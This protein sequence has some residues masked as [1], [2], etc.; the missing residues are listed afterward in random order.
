MKRIVMSLLCLAL[1][2]ENAYSYIADQNLF[3]ISGKDSRITE[4]DAYNRSIYYIEAPQSL[5]GTI[6]IRIFDADLAGKHDRW[7]S[8]SEVRYY[9]YGKGSID[10]NVRTIADP[11]PSQNP[12]TELRLGE[13]RDYDDQWRTI[14]APDISEGDPQNHHVYFQ[15]IVDGTKGKA[16]NKYQVFVSAHDKENELVDG[17]RIFSPVVMLALPPASDLATQIR[18][19]VPKDTHYL[20]IFNFDADET[21]SKITIDFETPFTQPISITPSKDGQVSSTQ[22]TIGAEERGKTGAIIL[23]NG[24]HPN[25]IQLWI[26]DDQERPVP[27]SLPMF[28]APRNHVPVPDIQVIPLSACFSAMLDASGSVDPDDDELTFEWIFPDGSRSQGSRIVHDFSRSGDYDVTLIVRDQS[29]FVANSSKLTQTIR[30]NEPPMAKI[31]APDKGIPQESLT[32]DASDSWDADGQI[33]TYHWNFGDGT[34]GEGKTSSHK[35]AGSGK[36]KITLVIEDDSHSLCRQSKATRWVRINAPPVPHL[37]LK[38]IGAVGETI[39]LDA[40]ASV[41][42]DGEIILYAWD[43]G[44]TTTTRGEKTSHQWEAP[45]K[46]TVRLR[47]TDNAGLGNSTTEETAE[48]VINARP[49]ALAKYAPVIAAQEDVIFDGTVSYDQDGTIRKYVWDTGDGTIGEGATIHHAYESPGLYTATLTVTDNTS[50]LNNT[51]STT[52][53]IRVNHPPIPVAGEDQLVDASE[54]AFDASASMDADDPIIDYLWEFGDGSQA[55]GKVVSHVYALPGTYPVTLT[56]TDGSGSRSASQSDTIKVTVNHPPIADAGGTRVVSVGEKLVFDGNFSDDP[57]GEIVSYLWQ[58]EA[59]TIVKE[60]CLEH[61]YDKPGIYQVR[62][63]VQDNVGAESTDYATIIVNAP[64]VADFYPVRRVAPGQTVLFDGTCSRDPDGQIRQALWDFGDNTPPQEG[65][66]TQHIFQNPGRY[67]VTLTVQ[68]DSEASNNQDSITRI[69]EV[70]YPPQADAGRDIHTCHQKIQFDGSKSTDPDGD[71]LTYYW[72]FGDGTRDRGRTAEHIYSSPGMYPVTLTADDGHGLSNS[73][74]Q[75]KLTAHVEAPPTARIQINSQTVCAGELVLFDASQSDD[76]EKGL[77]R[78]LWNLGDMKTVEGINPVRS[79][80]KG[81]D[82]TIRLR[83]TDDSQLPCNSAEAETVLHVIDAPIADAGDDQTVCANTPVQFDGTRSTGGGRSI[84]SYEWDFGDEQLGVGITPTHLYSQAG[85]YTARLLIT[86]TGEGE[87]DNVSEDE[88]IV[89]VTAAPV[90]SFQAKKRACAGE[91]IPFDASDSLASEGNITEFLWDFGDDTVGS[92]AQIRHTY[93]KPGE[94]RATLRIRTDSEQACNTG[95]YAQTIRINSEP[96]PTLQ[97]TSSDKA[98]FSG[99]VYNAD[100]YTLLR[101]SGIRSEDPD[102]YIRSYTWDFGDGQKENGPSVSHQYKNP[103]DYPVVL[104]IRDNSDTSCSTSTS[105]LLVR[106]HEP[107]PQSITGP[108]LVC[109]GQAVEYA[110]ALDEPVEWVFS[111]GTTATGPQVTKRF[112][113]PGKFQVQVK[114]GDSLMSTRD[115]TVA[116]LP[117]MTLPP[118][119]ETY[120]GDTVVIQPVYSRSDDFPPLLHWDMGDGTT[121]EAE[122]IRHVYQ[123]PGEYSIQLLVTGQDGPTCL[124]TLYHIPV[125]VHVPPVVEILVEPEQIFTGGARDVVLFEAV[126]KNDQER[127]NYHW[128]FGDGEKAIGKRVSHLYKQSGTFQAIVTLSAPMQNTSQTYDFSKHIEVQQRE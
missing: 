97:V 53:S 127:W 29:G 25:Y 82:Y 52:F 89:N 14:A 114:A 121:A 37:K 113:A 48:I 106:V 59:G 31:H 95:E 86:V 4:G 38:P 122:Q 36:F 43:F 69:L 19:D 99:Q 1:S 47:V 63:T 6:Y 71:F 79:Y 101:F 7:E 117:E 125:V 111:D 49:V 80:K 41:D 13:N 74:S 108:E 128:D 109:M 16:I 33:L 51:A 102:G 105:T 12:L 73:V 103:G 68:D 120:P 55:H 10:W 118:T 72:D 94:Y 64:P 20:S 32:F 28:L 100:I 90:A 50:T 87:C 110:V 22:V 123:E 8:G 81:G 34:T 30:I 11:L 9:L 104:Q 115:I 62:L 39:E 23:R 56:V 17:I 5:T 18:F 70:N 15:L 66:S 76:P 124:H 67:V 44:D 78:Y 126:T 2:C 54:V 42:S 45:G 35:Y 98:P 57:D 27:L 3:V 60:A 46:Y 116:T 24:K 107:I 88:V 21:E 77:L 26:F 83:V 84:K 85:E 40:T 92:G 91:S 93:M 112:T 119:I 96:L 61:Q 65:L 58:L 75:I